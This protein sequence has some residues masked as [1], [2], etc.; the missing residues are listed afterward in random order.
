[1]PY[2]NDISGRR[3][4]KDISQQKLADRLGIP[5]SLLSQIETGL[6]KP[7]FEI[8]DKIAIEL[9]CLVSQIYNKEDVE[10]K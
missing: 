10:A 7:N 6:V 9:E 8:M 4:R 3:N 5:R 1:M 2:D